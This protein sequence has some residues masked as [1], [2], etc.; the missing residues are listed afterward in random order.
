[1]VSIIQTNRETKLFF[2]ERLFQGVQ[3]RGFLKWEH[4]VR[5]MLSRTKKYFADGARSAHVNLEPNV[6]PS[7]RT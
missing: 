1:M 4:I 5:V 6:F 7:G 3:N 2:S